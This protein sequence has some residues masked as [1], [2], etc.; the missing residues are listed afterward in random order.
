MNIKSLAASFWSSDFLDNFEDDNNVLPS[1][2][3]LDP[4]MQSIYDPERIFAT[5]AFEIN[6]ANTYHPRQGVHLLSHREVYSLVKKSCY[7]FKTKYPDSRYSVFSGILFII[8][9]DSRYNLEPYT[10]CIAS[11]LIQNM[12][13]IDINRVSECIGILVSAMTSLS[14]ASLSLRG[15]EY[16][17]SLDPNL[18]RIFMGKSD[19]IQEVLKSNF[20]K[21]DFIKY[22]IMKQDVDFAITYGIHLDFWTV[23]TSHFFNIFSIHAR[24]DFSR[25]EVF[26]EHISLTLSSLV[27]TMNYEEFSKISNAIYECVF[28]SEEFYDF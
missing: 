24:E 5:I 25:K 16:I 3:T 20:R 9:E 28:E 13:D 22:N 23:A 27:K 19:D 7:R 17:I 15:P 8:E 12:D 11:E 26:I 1:F 21:E 18:A 2:R 14:G 10:A 4:K 6:M